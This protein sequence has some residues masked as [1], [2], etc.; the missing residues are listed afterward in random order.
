MFRLIRVI[1]VLPRI[2]FG[3]AGEGKLVEARASARERSD[4]TV[5][6]YS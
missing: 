2:V 3:G 6:R 4:L 5:P 1:S